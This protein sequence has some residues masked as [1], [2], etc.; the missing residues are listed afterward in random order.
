VPGVLCACAPFG[1]APGGWELA[2]G[3]W[4]PSSFGRAG[5]QVAFHDQQGW[6]EGQGADHYLESRGPWWIDANHFWAPGQGAPGFG[7]VNIIAFKQLLPVENLEGATVSFRLRTQ[8]LRLLLVPAG[9]GTAED[10][11]G[12]LYFWFE[13]ASLR[14]HAAD[15]CNEDVAYPGA[16]ACKN[17]DY[18][19]EARP[20]EG[21]AVA[22][23]WVDVEL[24]LA[25][26]AG[27]AC[28]GA[29]PANQPRYGCLDDIGRGL[30]R[31][32]AVGFVV[33]PVGSDPFD[34]DPNGRSNRGAILIDDFKI[35]VPIS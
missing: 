27:W 17:F 13:T 3:S 23:Q 35:V 14:E 1:C 19:L 26:D 34:D 4:P 9:D 28:L 18:V 12:H 22:D 16:G 33:A 5:C 30:R 15:V 8:E 7:L 11:Q 29:S 24:A 21:L 2:P 25:A 32:A 6:W 31:A 10:R 20:L